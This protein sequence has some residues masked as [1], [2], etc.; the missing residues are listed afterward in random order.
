M[1]KVFPFCLAKSPKALRFGS[2][3]L[4]LGAYA[5]K[6]LEHRP[7]APK[8]KGP[9]IELGCG[10]GLALLGLLSL[11]PE[12]EALGIDLNADLVKL[13]KINSTNMALDKVQ[14]LQIDL[15]EVST[16]KFADWQSKASLVLA[17]PPWRLPTEGRRSTHTGRG[18]AL[19]AETDSFTIF[20][21]AAAFFL[22]HGGQFCCIINPSSLPLLTKEM[23]RCK[24]GLREILPLAPYADKPAS[25]LLLR[26]QK[27]AKALPQ[28]L[29][30]LVLHTNKGAKETRGKWSDAAL[31]FCPWLACDKS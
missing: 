31:D 10:D 21:K 23:E 14:F 29:P 2:D 13:A 9:L 25:R 1:Y 15:R 24:L 11:Y 7:P 6:Y 26:S 8:N 30:P 18:R 20:S 22:K 28:L 5:A 12:Y 19:W 16:A 4:L 3:A 27:N 17:N